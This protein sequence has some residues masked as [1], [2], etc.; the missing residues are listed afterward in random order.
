MGVY[1]HHSPNKAFDIFIFLH[2]IDGSLGEKQFEEL[3]KTD[4]SASSLLGTFLS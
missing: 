4:R 2:Q 1:H 3:A